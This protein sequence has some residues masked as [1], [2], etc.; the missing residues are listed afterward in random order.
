MKITGFRIKITEEAG[1]PLWRQLSSNRLDGGSMCGRTGCVT[2]KQSDEK[3]LDCFQR[4]VVYESSCVICHPGEVKEKPGDTLIKDGRGVYVGETSRSVFERT[5]EHQDDAT[6]LDEGSHMVKHWFTSHKE[7]HYQPEFRFK[8]IGKYK[9]CLTRQLKEAVRI[10]HRPGNLNSKGEWGASII[11]RLR[12]E[13]DEFARKRDELEDRK[14][15]EKEEQELQE[16]I[17]MKRMGTKADQVEELE[18]R[19]RKLPE[20]M[21]TGSSVKRI[22]IS[23]SDENG[24][25]HELENETLPSDGWKPTIIGNTTTGLV[26]GGSEDSKVTTTYVTVKAEPKETR[27]KKV[28][29]RGGRKGKGVSLFTVREIAAFFKNIEKNLENTPKRKLQNQD[30]VDSPTKKG[31]FC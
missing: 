30:C 10:S 3:K 13:K 16:F 6:K 28:L 21:L 14:M 25:Q 18:S 26:A 31:K 5:S 9:D 11:P 1:I 12:I 2:C 29:V 4:S 23:E 8:V 24:S 22:R 19:K 17:L 7:E 27:D 20:W 15:K